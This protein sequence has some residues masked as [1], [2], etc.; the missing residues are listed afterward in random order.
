MENVLVDAPLLFVDFDGVLHPGGSREDQIFCRMPLLADALRGPLSG[1]DLVISSDWRLVYGVE[2]LRQH[3]PAD[4]RRRVL[5]CTPLDT[6]VT[7]RTWGAMAVQFPRQAQIMAWVA[8]H[9]SSS[10][11]PWA[12]LDDRPE[13][14]LPGEAR[15][16]VVSADR[17]LQP[18]HLDR[19]AEI[20]KQQQAGHG[21]W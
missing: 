9:R 21:R 4:L 1:V 13:W 16:V 17:G 7:P 11:H 8:R 12:A 2:D 6:Q 10:Q 5:G 19:V 20:L 14:F 18:E 3:F 15:L